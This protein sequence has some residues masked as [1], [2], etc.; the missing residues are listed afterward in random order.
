MI[1]FLELPNKAKGLQC[2]VDRRKKIKLT[3]LMQSNLDNAL[4]I[5][6]TVCL[7]NVCVDHDLVYLTIVKFGVLFYAVKG[8]TGCQSQSPFG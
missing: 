1:A 6:V 3:R 2:Q 5:R 8:R 4:T 7:K